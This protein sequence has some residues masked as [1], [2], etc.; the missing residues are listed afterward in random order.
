MI[1]I[2]AGR[3]I[4][5]DDAKEERFPLRNAQKVSKSVRARLK[6]LHPSMLICSAACGS[7]LIVLREA[8]SLGIRS[9]IV[10][11]FPPGRFRSTSV[12]DRPGNDVT[13]DWG[14]IFDEITQQA[15]DGNDLIVL[16]DG[17][18]DESAAYSA[19]NRR[20]ISE[21]QNLSHAATEL[22]PDNGEEIRALIIWEGSSRGEDD[23]T[24][25]MM[26]MAKDAGILVEQVKTI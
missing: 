16:P 18:G 14:A 10:L 7:D 26:K 22:N 12:I 11:P 17:V 4:D 19:A 21:A 20:I 5:A 8:Q 6:D 1:I 3:R 24:E 13:W 23:L 2:S 25:E 15:S 9:R